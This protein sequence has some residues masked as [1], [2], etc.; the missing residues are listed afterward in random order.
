MIR[1]KS[2]GYWQVKIMVE[3]DMAMFLSIETKEDSY[4]AS[5]R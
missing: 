4:A 3:L 1:A 5:D 2:N